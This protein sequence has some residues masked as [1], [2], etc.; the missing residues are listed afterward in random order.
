MK[1]KCPECN[2]EREV[3]EKKE[4]VGMFMVMRCKNE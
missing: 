3:F 1:Y 4:L 2:G